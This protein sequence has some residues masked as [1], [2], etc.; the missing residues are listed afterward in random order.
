MTLAYI[1]LFGECGSMLSSMMVGGSPGLLRE[2]KTESAFGNAEEG[3][4]HGAVHATTCLYPPYPGD[5]GR[6]GRQEDL[7]LRL[8]VTARS[9]LSGTYP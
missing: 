7:C 3:A 6:K 2:S 1:P 8:C 5:E 4:V 9:A